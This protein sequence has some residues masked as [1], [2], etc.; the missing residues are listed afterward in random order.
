MADT[1]ERLERLA[2][3]GHQLRV[4]SYSHQS[5]VKELGLFSRAPA[6][7]LFRGGFGDW[8][9][10]KAR[11]AASLAGLRKQTRTST[12]P[13][14]PAPLRA[15]D[16]F[17]CAHDL[18]QS[19]RPSESIRSQCTSQ[20]QHGVEGLRREIGVAPVGLLTRTVDCNCKGD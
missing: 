18:S 10:V 13:T 2:G 12:K 14:G 5:T 4:G 3:A 20:S 19:R 17:N 7:S 11:A 1:V 8:N 15:V 16:A 6:N 9:D